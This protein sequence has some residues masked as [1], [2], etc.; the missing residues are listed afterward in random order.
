MKLNSSQEIRLFNRV[1]SA[2]T[3][4][5]DAGSLFH[6]EQAARDV[7]DIFK[8]YECPFEGQTNLEPHEPCPVCGML[9]DDSDAPDLCVAGG[10]R[11]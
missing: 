8:S 1:L 11:R 7:L 2:I 3:K 5:C 10:H 4:N 6:P 9:G